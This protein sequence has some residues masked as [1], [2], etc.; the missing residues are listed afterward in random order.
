MTRYHP[1]D[2]KE[3]KGLISYR[4]ISSKSMTRGSTINKVYRSSLLK[5]TVSE[6]RLNNQA[7]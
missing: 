6:F 7:F 2:D 5:S 4:S 1:T 3:F